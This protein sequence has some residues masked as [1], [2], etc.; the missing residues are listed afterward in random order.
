MKDTQVLSVDIGGSHITTALVDM[1][2]R[3]FLPDS[4]YREHIDSHAGAADIISRWSYVMKKS[5][6]AGNNV[7]RIGI[8]MPGPFDYEEG[9][10]LIK[11]LHKYDALYGLNVKDLLE[12]Q[13]GID[14]KDIRI[15][16]D[17][18]CFLQGELFNGAVKGEKEVLGLTL[19]TGFG[20][21]VADNGIA[22]EGTFWKTPFLDATAEEYF[23]T[24]WFIRRYEELSGERIKSVKE[25]AAIAG[26][27][28][29]A[30][31]VFQEFGYNLAMFLLEQQPIPALVV[32]GGNITQAFHLFRANLEHHMNGTR[33]VVSELGEEAIL[34]GAAGFWEIPR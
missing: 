5:M 2:R 23:S 11:G 19:G 15:M 30:F 14:K 34:L 10:S 33:F 26:Q 22:Q 7:H 1:Q 28:T 25:L 4:I 12:E 6:L 31:T 8:A 17:A 21:S 27:S 32:L 20:S 3:T 24:R 18:S 29:Y 9:I 16:N 13:L